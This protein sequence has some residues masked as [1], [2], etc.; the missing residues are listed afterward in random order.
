MKFVQSLYFCFCVFLCGLSLLFAANP[1]VEYT[2][3]SESAAK[4][5]QLAY[6]DDI[7]RTVKTLTLGD[8]KLKFSV[9]EQIRAYDVV[10][11]RYTLLSPDAASESCP[12]G[13]PA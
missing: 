13:K 8:Y 4:S 1:M 6:Y 10:P 5:G 3:L 7:P 11:I 2:F 12:F 9:P